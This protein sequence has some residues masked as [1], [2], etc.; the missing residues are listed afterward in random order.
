MDGSAF[1]VPAV[2]TDVQDVVERAEEVAVVSSGLLLVSNGHE[3]VL[4][5]VRFP[6]LDC[7]PDV[8][9]L[10]DLAAAVAYLAGND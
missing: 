10:D 9:P 4:C 2:G 8:F 5:R 3:V 7:G 1:P 6:K